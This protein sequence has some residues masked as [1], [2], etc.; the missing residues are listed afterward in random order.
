[1]GLPSIV[2]DI[3]GSREIIVE[4]ENGVIIPSHDANALFDAMLNMMRDKDA[5]EKMAGKAR[6][7]IASRF[8][9]GFVRKCL[10]GFYDEILPTDK[11]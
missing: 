10:Y 8:E 4:G 5:R 7:M 9:Q 6:Q 3:N 1:M 2:T 11:K